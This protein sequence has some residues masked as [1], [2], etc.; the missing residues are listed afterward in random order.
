M[1]TGSLEG[2]LSR[3]ASSRALSSWSWPLSGA[4]ALDER[5]SGGAEVAGVLFMFVLSTVEG[6]AGLEAS[7]NLLPAKWR[8]LGQAGGT[9]L[10]A[11]GRCLQ[12]PACDD[13]PGWKPGT[14]GGWFR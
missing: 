10:G 14:A 6:T 1:A 8:L 2:K 13:A 7:Q 12:Y 9:G 4:S 5:W 11:A 3:N